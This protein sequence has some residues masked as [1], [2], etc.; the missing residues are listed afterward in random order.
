[1]G[2]LVVMVGLALASSGVVAVIGALVLRMMRGRS[3]LAHVMTLLGVTVAS[4]LAGVVA[5]AQAMFI[6]AHDLRVLLI[7]LG[8][9]SLVSLAVVLAAG[10]RLGQA[11]MWASEAYERERRLERSRREVVAWVS[12]DLRTPLA[13][14][15]AMTEALEDRV[16]SAPEAVAD[17]HQRMRVEV[18]RLSALVD[19]LFELSRIDAGALRLTMHAVS[20]GDVVSDAVAV[21]TPMAQAKGVRLVSSPGGYGVVAASEPELGRVFVNLLV[22]AIRHTPADGVVTVDGGTDDSSGWVQ[23]TDG[24]G[25]IP[26]RDLERVFDVAFRGEAARGR[27]PDDEVTRAGR[28]GLGLAIVRGLVAEHNGSVAVANVDGGCRFTVRLPIAAR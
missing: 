10:R 14:L 6:S 17:Y 2:E 28:G 1:M 8:V 3:V 26:E 25:G 23:V 4:V 5:V 20:L 16:V 7:V 21:A 11:S 24:C 12:H 27:L 9:A 22:N 15:R 13:G 18:D 19:D